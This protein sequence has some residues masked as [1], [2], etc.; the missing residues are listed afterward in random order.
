MFISC[1]CLRVVFQKLCVFCGP[2]FRTFVFSMLVILLELFYSGWQFVWRTFVIWAKHWDFFYYCLFVLF[3]PCGHRVAVAP[4]GRR[5]ASPRCG[6]RLSWAAPRL[7]LPPPAQPQALRL[8]RS[9]SGFGPS[10]SLFPFPFPL[11]LAAKR[12]PC[13]GCHA[14]P[15]AKR[16]RDAR[17]CGSGERRGRVR[18]Y[19]KPLGNTMIP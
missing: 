4:R 18:E 15:L 11:P 3:P 8:P 5:P 12:V 6:R 1:M 14:P 19:Y 17:D 9:S 2:M 10:F 7:R 13:V 16:P